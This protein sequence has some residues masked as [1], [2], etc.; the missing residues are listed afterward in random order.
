METTAYIPK[1]VLQYWKDLEHLSDNN[2]VVLIALLSNSIV[3]KK[4]EK[5][6][7]DP[8]V[9]ELQNSHR[10][11]VSPLLKAVELGEDRSIGLSDD[12][13]KEIGERKMKRALL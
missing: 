1:E 8:K 4:D 12:Y 13:K 5:R 9:S 6:D 7:A 10:I 3:K 2:K 11:T